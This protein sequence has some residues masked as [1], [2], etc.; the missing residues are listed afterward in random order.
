MQKSYLLT[1]QQCSVP[2]VEYDVTD[3]DQ[4]TRIGRHLRVSLVSFHRGAVG[5]GLLYFGVDTET[6]VDNYS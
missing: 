1:L 5:G 6:G 4:A 2:L 3:K